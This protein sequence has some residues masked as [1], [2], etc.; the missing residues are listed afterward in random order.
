VAAAEDSI[1]AIGNK[2]SQI[3]GELRM[4]YRDLT[5]SQSKYR[6]SPMVF[7][8]E[9][10]PQITRILGRETIQSFITAVMQTGSM[11]DI[12]LPSS[13]TA[14][15]DLVSDK[16]SLLCSYPDIGRYRPMKRAPG[17]EDHRPL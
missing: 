7:L 15:E 14:R 10:M 11:I 9:P 4:G 3:V 12:D 17:G 8:K 1:S 2:I 13:H 16:F 5:A 6:D